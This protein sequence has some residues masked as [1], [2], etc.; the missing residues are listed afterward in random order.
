MLCARP[1]SA[2]TRSTRTKRSDSVRTARGSPLSSRRRGR[3]A[4][5]PRSQSPPSRQ[6]GAGPQRQGH[7]G[8]GARRPRG[9]HRHDDGQR[10]VGHRDLR[11]FGGIRTRVD[12]G[13]DPRW[14]GL[15][16]SQGQ[17]GRAPS[18]AELSAGA[19]SSGSDGAARYEGQRARPGARRNQGD[20]LPLR[21]AR[22][23]LEKPRATG[24]GSLGGPD[25]AIILR[26]EP[27]G[28]VAGQALDPQHPRNRVLG[29]HFG[30]LRGASL[31]PVGTTCRSSGR[32]WRPPG[33]E[34]HQAP[35]G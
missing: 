30:F 27:L 11:G 16:T 34:E 4:R 2:T 13:T 28:G 10:K 29:N 26:A 19:A 12:P 9:R 25:R 31:L 14:I 35:A 24:P 1:A 3:E 32:G 22:W 33:A 20:D 6:P 8:P 5:S 18:R 7:R 21:S 17:E 15:C 23:L